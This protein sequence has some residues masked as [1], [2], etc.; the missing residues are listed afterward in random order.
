MLIQVLHDI[1]EKHGVSPSCVATRWVLQQP[2]VSA[3]IVG[4]RNATHIRVSGAYIPKSHPLGML[5]CDWCCS[6]LLHALR[7]LCMPAW[8]QLYCSCHT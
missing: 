6:L 1:G 8:Q 2:G 3:V 4:A 5:A 7:A